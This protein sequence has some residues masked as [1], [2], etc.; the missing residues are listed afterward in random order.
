M[1]PSSRPDPR[2]QVTRRA[3]IVW[4][5][6]VLFYIVAITGRTSF[7]VAGV[8]AIARFEVDASRIAVFTAVQV[9]VYAL[10]Q[11]PVGLL[12]DRFGSRRV[13][14]IGAVLMGVGQIILGLTSN[15]WVAILARVFIGA[16]DASAFLSAMRLLP[17]WFPARITPLFTQLTSGLGQLGQFFSAVPFLWLL[18]AQGWTVAF[19]SLGAVGILVAIAAGVAISDAPDGS[20]DEDSPTD[21]PEPGQLTAREM[22]RKKSRFFNTLSTV[23]KHP[24]CWQGFFIHWTGMLNQIVFTLLWGV[25]LMTLGMGLDNAQVGLV[26]TINTISTIA[27]GPLLGWVSQRT[28]YNRDLAVVVLAGIIGIAW[29]IFILPAEPRSLAA[30]IVVNII[31]AVFTP[32]ANFG[33]DN[34]RARVHRRVVA[35]GTGL[36]NMGGF[37]SGML[38]AQLVGITL[39]ASSAGETYQWADFR[40]GWLVVLVIWALG[41]TGILLTRAWV[42][43]WEKRAGRGVRIVDSSD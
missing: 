34:V 14:I 8:D 1:S 43:R 12:I 36:G 3:L 7:G 39:D 35:T 37:L 28:G 2:Q 6:A 16:G 17:F 5:A 32:T 10:A 24:L 11:I 30:I 26:L 4:G 20:D 19:V 22:R 40:L 29:L 18:G 38:A 27:A 23:L 13:L 41:M 42:K 31:M 33:F 15:Y 9:G 25:P 21:S